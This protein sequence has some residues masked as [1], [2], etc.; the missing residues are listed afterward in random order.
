MLSKLAKSSL[1]KQQYRIVGSHSAVKVCGWTKNMIRGVGGC[2][3]LTFYGIMSNQCLQMTTSISCANRCTFC[4]RDYKA[5]VSKK[6]EWDVDDPDKIFDESVEAHHKL[7]IGFNGSKKFNKG[8]FENSKR[9]KHVA[10]SLTGEPIIYPKMNELIKRFNKEGVSTFMVT[11]GQYP[12]QIK[13]LAPVT[14]LYISV[15][16]PNKKILKEVDKP[17]FT[18]YWERLLESLDYLKQKKQR[19]CIRLT[20]IHKV[21]MTD[22][23]GYK[24]LIERGDPDF[25]E[26]KAYMW[27]GASQSR[28]K[29]ENMPY[30]ADIESFTKELIKVLSEYEIVSEH[31]PSRVVL[32]AKKTFN[33]NEKWHT[34][35]DFNK[36]HELVM[37][38][39]EVRTKDYVKVTPVGNILK[40]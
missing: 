13:D 20:M 15:D 35:I 39:N 14:Q 16:A 8:A 37:G 26:V 38:G 12:R 25:I 9:V 28:L 33:V 2:Y 7:L 40:P 31:V 21:N 5:P 24:M 11:N 1:E 19:T 10:L 34:W 32:L 3:K 4:W 23:D 27:V 6:W 17:L 29:E 18:D 36:Y 22:L 30:H